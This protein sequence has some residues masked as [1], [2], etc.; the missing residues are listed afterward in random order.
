MLHRPFWL[1]R[2]LVARFS[3]RL[4]ATEGERFVSDLLPK[5]Y[6][7]LTLDLLF[8]VCCGT[9]CQARM[10]I[11]WI[12]DQKCERSHGTLLNQWT[13]SRGSTSPT[14]PSFSSLARA[15]S[16]LE[17]AGNYWKCQQCEICMQ[18]RHKSLVMTSWPSVLKGLKIFW[19]EPNIAK[20]QLSLQV[21][22]LWSCCIRW[23]Q[24][25]QNID[26]VGLHS[27]FL[28]PGEAWSSGR[29]Y[30]CGRLQ[31][32]GGHCS[33]LHWCCYIKVSIYLSC[34]LGRPI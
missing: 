31:C 10:S 1:Q 15:P 3:A 23:C 16:L 30:G 19:I 9:P 17:W 14:D 11:H 27:P 4:M 33:N 34:K 25:K 6:M 8:R 12:L 29:V 20:Q 24:P 22:R 7:H 5:Q 13:L 26:L 28:R 21:L 18:R 32:W 2:C